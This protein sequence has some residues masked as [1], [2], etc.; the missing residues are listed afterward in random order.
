MVI[1]YQNHPCGTLSKQELVPQGN[2][3]NCM[4]GKE[5]HNSGAPPL[6]YIQREA[7]SRSLSKQDLDYM[8]RCDELKSGEAYAVPATVVTLDLGW[9]SKNHRQILSRRQHLKIIVHLWDRA[10][11][12]RA[13]LHELDHTK[14]GRLYG[15]NYSGRVDLSVN[16]AASYYF[17]T[18]SG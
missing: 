16:R 1:A 14:W 3:L 5:K 17:C 15:H 8:A 9:T 6:P 4:V 12:S 7:L 2:H 10:L 18:W 13:R 11:Q